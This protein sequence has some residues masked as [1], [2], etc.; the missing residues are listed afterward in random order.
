MLH[1]L[2]IGH[3]VDAEERHWYFSTA[4]GAVT[5]SGH[6]R[7]PEGAVGNLASMDTLIEFRGTVPRNRPEYPIF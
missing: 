6:Q 7:E 4:L 5:Q 1:S 2:A 3:D